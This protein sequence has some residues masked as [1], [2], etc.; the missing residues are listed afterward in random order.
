M[1]AKTCESAPGP[2]CSRTIGSGAGVGLRDL[3]TA[4]GS[5]IV[6]PPGLACRAGTTA[7]PQTTVCPSCWSAGSLNA[8][9]PGSKRGTPLVTGVGTATG[10]TAR[11]ATGA[12]GV[13]STDPHRNISVSS[14]AGTPRPDVLDIGQLSPSQLR[15]PSVACPRHAI[16]PPLQVRRPPSG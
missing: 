6:L 5:R 4:T 1:S 14:K 12:T 3:K 11:A 10:A 7:Q 9:A 2:P 16:T 8:H 15:R 13:V